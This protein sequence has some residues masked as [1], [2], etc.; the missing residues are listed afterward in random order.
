MSNSTG[1]FVKGRADLSTAQIRAHGEIRIRMAVIWLVGVIC[2]ILSLCGILSLFVLPDSFKDI[3]VTIGPIISA[4][5]TGTVGFLM[6]EKRENT[7]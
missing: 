3:W 2:S 7:E 6:G 4:G 5:L 1:T